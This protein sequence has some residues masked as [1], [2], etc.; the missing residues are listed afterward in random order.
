MMR[1]QFFIGS[2]QLRSTPEDSF[3]VPWKESRRS[4]ALAIICVIVLIL[5]LPSWSA[6]DFNNNS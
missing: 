2:N 6:L 5:V 3:F 1:R 4:V